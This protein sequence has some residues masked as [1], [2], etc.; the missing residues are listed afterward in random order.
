MKPSV[1]IILNRL[2]IGGQ[3]VDTIP[4]AYY[5]Q[6]D[7]TIV[8]LYGEKETDEIEANFLLKQYPGLQVKKLRLLRRTVNPFIDFL[9]F[10]SIIKQLKFFRADIVHTHGSK[11]GLLGRLA[12]WFLQVPVIVHTFHGH[13]FHSYFN[14]FGSKWVRIIEKWLA[15]I[16]TNIV[17]L[18]NEQK[19]ELT[20][21]F[22]IAPTN[23]ISVIQLGV[24]EH[25]LQ[26]GTANSRQKFRNQF[27]LSNTAVAVG[28]IGRIVPIK[29]QLLFL[30]VAK[31]TLDSGKQDVYFFVVGDG[32]SKK[33]MVDYMLANKIAFSDVG[34]PKDNARVIFTSWVE[35][36]AAVYNGMDIIVL[37]SFNEGT[38]LAIIEAQFCG[39]PVIASNVG[40]VKDTFQPEI[41]GFLVDGFRVNNYVAA[42]NKLIDNNELRNEMGDAAIQFA[43]NSF[44]KSKEVEA[45][46]N[47][48]LKQLSKTKP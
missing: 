46:K 18:S 31:A 25:V 5:L 24:D 38:P 13:L 9:A 26:I 34:K 7:F 47:L 20:E 16:S 40:G 30:E 15:S 2:V 36:M 14:S 21:I 10:I 37:T 43:N 22:N 6:Q 1:V 44:A 39:K 42:L 19:K 23:K 28:S 48:Y 11:S 29:N 35:D 4:L 33:E 27:Q 17:A 41:S 12:A 45:M 3:A 8:I 32:E